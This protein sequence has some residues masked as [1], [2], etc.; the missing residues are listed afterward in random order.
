MKNAPATADSRNNN[1]TQ[2]LQQ[3]HPAFRD[4]IKNFIIEVPTAIDLSQA[5]PG[6]LFALATDFGTLRQRNKAR[7][8]LANGAPLKDVAEALSLP[9]WMRRL[10]A[11]AFVNRLHSFPDDSEF[12]RRI[13]TLVPTDPNAGAAWLRGVLMGL[14]RCHPAFALWAASWLE[15]QHRSIGLPE[16]EDKFW[17]LA[18]W[19]WHASYPETTGH[20]ML[21]RMWTPQISLRRA[22][23]ELLSWRQRMTLA[24]ILEAEA[25]D[26]WLLPG[27][28]LDYEFVPLVSADDFVIESEKMSNCLD[29]Y[30]DKLVRNF[31]RIFAVRKMGRSIAN[32][33]IGLDDQDGRMPSILQLRGPRNRRTSAELWRAVYLWLGSQPLKPRTTRSTRLDPEKFDTAAH[34]I[35]APYLREMK[36][37]GCEDAFKTSLNSCR[38]K[39]RRLSKRPSRRQNQTDGEQAPSLGTHRSRLRQRN[40]HSRQVATEVRLEAKVSD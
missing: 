15:R 11:N 17:L 34:T 29:Q 38:L 32:V 21:R 30:A 19:A 39:G 24:I 27:A 3:F 33:E 35:W 36:K 37:I 28:A 31:S 9:W 12:H 2:V 22:L 5:F 10:A 16:S 8:L 14:E 6:L 18:A 26:R 25:N 23:D 7:R 40:S 4:D 20:R 13:A 1:V